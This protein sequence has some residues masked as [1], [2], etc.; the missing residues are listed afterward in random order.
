MTSEAFLIASAYAT[1]QSSPPVSPMVLLM[2][3]LLLF[4]LAY[5]SCVQ[6]AVECLR[7]KQMTPEV[8]KVLKDLGLIS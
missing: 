4:F 5:A 7:F 3:G 2:A 1:T 8:Q 6:H